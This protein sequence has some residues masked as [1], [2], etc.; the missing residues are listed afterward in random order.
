MEEDRH[1]E[2]FTVDW[3]G[4]ALSVTYE[5]NW[6]NICTTQWD[7]ARAHLQIRSVGPERARLPITETGYRSHFLDS[8][9][10]AVAG[11]PVAYV[12]AWLDQAADNQVWREYEASIRQGSLF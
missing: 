12:I 1:I 9:E 3:R 6:L 4:I 7:M 5:A 8:D 11:G 2:T 10:I